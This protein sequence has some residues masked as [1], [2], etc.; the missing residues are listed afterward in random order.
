MK[1]IRW[2]RGVL[3]WGLC[4]TVV[5]CSAANTP[6]SP[7]GGPELPAESE[8]P[9]A[10]PTLPEAPPGETPEAPPEEETPGP[11][12]TVCAP[13]AGEA[14][15]VLEGEPLSVKV[16][17]GTGHSA[18]GLRFAVENLPPGAS[19]D[20]AS[21]TLSWTPGKDQAAV[22][23]LLLKEQST[24]EAGTLKVGVAENKNAPGNVPI[25]NPAAY[26]EEYGLPVLHLTHDERGLTAGEYRPVQILYRGRAYSIEAKFRG[27][28]SS[29]FPKRS[30]TLK[31]PDEDL[32]NEPVFGGGFTDRKRVVLITT[33]NDNSYLRSRLAFDLWNRMDPAHV[34]IRT[35]SAVLYVNNRYKGLY[36]VADHINKR[37]MAAHGLSKDSDLFKAVD[38]DANFSRLRKDGT[39]KAGLNEGFEK[40]EGIPEEGRPHAFDTLSSLIGFVS[41]SDAAT[42]R[43]GFRSRLGGNDYQDWWIFNTLI[44]GTDSQGKNAYHAF[45]PSTEG[46][47]RFIPWDLDASLGQNF[48][49]TRSSPTAR[50]TFA[51]DNLLF[52]RMLAE[53][54]LAD[55]MRERYQ[56]VL[57]DEL[58]LETVLSLID[59]YVRETAPAARRDWA[60][61][62]T[63]YQA[64]GAPGTIGQPNFPRWNSRQD[65]TTYEQEVEYV[66]QWVRTR[67]PALEGRLP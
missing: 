37:L 16:A 22:W 35:F 12:P 5:G 11:A 43:T 50:P 4:L 10:A 61:W 6:P 48:D 26:T 38:K 21:G 34:Q 51:E 40:E 60:E 7:E 2:L 14:R 45:D 3:G 58:K 23:N 49:T 29:V 28:T 54:A 13:T 55:P 15:W 39:P 65:F 31:F 27:A 44:L 30:L 64:F 52:S 63:A 62:S 66:R 32:F 24:G 17:C 53:P 41:D 67:W 8:G 33:F 18:P 59:G 19:F 1:G 36:T 9:P 42:F 20:A 25:V 46:P 57:R 56:R 47:W